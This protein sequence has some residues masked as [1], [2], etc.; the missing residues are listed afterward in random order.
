MPINISWSRI[1]VWMWKL[2]LDL[3]RFFQLFTVLERICYKTVSKGSVVQCL[4]CKAA[5]LWGPDLL[6]WSVSRVG[7]CF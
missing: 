4:P 3:A 2:S 7:L 5:G 6:E 1:Y